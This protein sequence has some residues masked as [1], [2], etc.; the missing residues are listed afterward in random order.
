MS[1]PLFMSPAHVD[2]MNAILRDAPEAATAAPAATAEPEVSVVITSD[3]SRGEVLA[4]AAALELFVDLDGRFLHHRMRFLRPSKK[5]EVLAAGKT[6]M[7]VFGIKSQ[8]Q[9]C[10]LCLGLI[11]FQ[12]GHQ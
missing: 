3:L 6:L 1:K 4:F 7:T 5:D 2:E 9:Q 10:G 12:N 11:A 8:A